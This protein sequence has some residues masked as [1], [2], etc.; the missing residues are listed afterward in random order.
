M[1]N[2]ENEYKLNHIVKKEVGMKIISLDN[3]K[4]YVYNEDDVIITKKNYLEI[5]YIINNWHYKVLNELIDE[6]KIFYTKIKYIISY[7][8]SYHIKVSVG[9]LLSCTF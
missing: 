6:N 2:I 4:K 5:E 1:I 3:P 9:E 7:I 8:S